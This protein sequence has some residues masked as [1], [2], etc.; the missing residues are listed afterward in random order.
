MSRVCPSKFKISSSP[1]KEISKERK[2]AMDAAS[3]GTLWKF[4]QTSPHPRQKKKACKNQAL[5]SIRSWDDS[6]SE[7][8]HHHKR[9]GHKHSSSS[10]S[11]VCLMARGN[12]SSSLVRVIVMIICLLIV[13]LCKKILIMLKLALVNKKSSKV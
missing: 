9:R 12:E 3:W 8:E 5:T 4:V 10:S 6:S 7:E 1:I 2:D 11:R 13:N